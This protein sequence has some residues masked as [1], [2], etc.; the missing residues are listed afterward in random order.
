MSE[1]Q[2]T[3]EPLRDD[4]IREGDIRLCRRVPATTQAVPVEM[5]ETLRYTI[6]VALEARRE[7]LDATHCDMCREAVEEVDDALAWLDSQGQDADS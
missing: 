6:R 3:W 4:D 1:Q 2:W 7:S 5:S